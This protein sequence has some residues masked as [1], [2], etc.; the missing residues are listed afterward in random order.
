MSKWGGKENTTIPKCVVPSAPNTL[1]MS[2]L[3]GE[4][5]NDDYNTPDTSQ[6]SL[7][8]LIVSAGMV[9]DSAPNTVQP[10]QMSEFYGKEKSSGGGGCL[11]FGTKI[12]MANGSETNIEDIIV[13][14]ELLSMSIPGMPLDFDAE[15]TWK[16]WEVDSIDGIEQATATVIKVTTNTYAT[17]Y[18]INGSLRATYEHPF[19]VL[20]NGSYQ[21]ITAENLILGDMLYNSNNE[22]EEIETV[23]LVDEELEVGNL[24]VESL[25]VYFGGGYLLHNKA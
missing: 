15:D 8:S 9:W 6:V 5:T 19:F 24:N 2:G 1:T 25:D 4:H 13:G 16:N 3:N 23:G 7:T 21:F 12:I 22:F 11:A 18:L 10:H 20:R 14:D 17:H